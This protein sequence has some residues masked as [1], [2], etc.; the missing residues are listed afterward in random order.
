MVAA[1]TH[2]EDTLRRRTATLTASTALLALGLVTAPGV[3]TATPSPWPGWTPPTQPVRSYASDVSGYQQ[4]AQHDGA[5]SGSVSRKATRVWTR[6]LGGTVSYP[7]VAGSTVYVTYDDPTAGTKLIALDRTTGATVWGPVTIPGPDGF[8][9][10]TYAAGRLFVLGHNGILRAFSA[11]DGSPSWSVALPDQWSFTAAPVAAGSRVYV[12][13]AGSGGTLYAVEQA[14]GAIDWTR[15]VVNGDAAAPA[16]G[17]DSVYTSF[18][19]EWTQAF[20]NAGQAGWT[21][22]FG[23]DG[24]GGSTP[25]LSGDQLWVRDPDGMPGRVLSTQDG[26]V[27]FTFDADY[28]PAVA[29]GRTVTVSSQ[30]VRGLDAATG[31]QLWAQSADGGLSTPAVVAGGVAYVG[32]RLGS[33]FGVD[34]RTGAIVWKGAAGDL[35]TVDDH[36][37]VVRTGL[38]VS[39]NTLLVPA[40]DRLVAFR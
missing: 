12:V 32:S 18:A 27:R 19:C 35:V 28:A 8:S 37:A 29:G 26:S 40:S 17:S 30:G 22:T 13:G 20:T 23:C 39:G 24:G 3:A 38:A 36:N 4:D 34:V 10:A 31:R 7:V 21:D 14:S 33:V 9:A 11:K 6:A 5:S 16:V 15:S 25:V 1:A 2:L